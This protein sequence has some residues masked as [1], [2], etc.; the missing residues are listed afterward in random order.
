MDQNV[1]NRCKITNT[2]YQDEKKNNKNRAQLAWACLLR[3]DQ[4]QKNKC[5][6]K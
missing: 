5:K 3:V 6:I 2:K 4:N 1:K